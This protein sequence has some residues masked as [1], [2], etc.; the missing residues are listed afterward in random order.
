MKTLTPLALIVAMA[1][2]GGCATSPVQ[3][4]AT[5][6]EIDYQKVNLVNDWARR[7]NVEV[8]WVNYPQKSTRSTQ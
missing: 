4:V 1:L 8:V 3:T 2:I 5:A 7:N 6:Y